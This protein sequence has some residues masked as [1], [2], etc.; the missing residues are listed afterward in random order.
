MM[1]AFSARRRAMVT[2]QVSK[3][4]QREPSRVSGVTV[5][6]SHQGLSS[7]SAP[8]SARSPV[9]VPSIQERIDSMS[10]RWDASSPSD[11]A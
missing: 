1:L 4:G 3:C 7:P 8:I 6:R 5:S 9:S 2:K 10:S 11:A